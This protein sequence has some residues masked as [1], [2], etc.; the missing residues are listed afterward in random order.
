[1]PVRHRLFV[2]ITAWCLVALWPALLFGQFDLTPSAPL[3]PPVPF[4]NQQELSIKE[5]NALLERQIEEFRDTISEVHKRDPQKAARMVREFENAIKLIR[6]HTNPTGGGT[7]PIMGMLTPIATPRFGIASQEIQRLQD[8]GEVQFAHAF[9]DQLAKLKSASTSEDYQL[10]TRTQPEIHRVRL[11]SGT[12]MPV[13]YRTKA[14]RFNKSYAEVHVQRTGA[15]VILVLESRAPM[16]WNIKASPGVDVLAV[17]VE[18]LSSQ[19][20]IGLADP[21]LLDTASAAEQQL[22]DFRTLG[23]H[24]RGELLAGSTATTF[25]SAEQYQEPIILG[26]ASRQWLADFL[27]EQTE[28]LIRACRSQ[29][30]SREAKRFAELRYSAS[31]PIQVDANARQYC[32]AEFN[33]TGPI[34]D[35]L[36]PHPGRSLRQSLI[37][38][39]GKKAIHFGLSTSGALVTHDPADSSNVNNSSPVPLSGSIF[40]RNTRIRAFAYDSK[41]HRL[42]C[43]PTGNQGMLAALDIESGDWLAV[44]QYPHPLIG[45]AYA[46]ESDEIWAVATQYA[47]VSATTWNAATFLRMDGAGKVTSAKPISH[48]LLDVKSDGYAGT[49]VNRFLNQTLELVVVGEYA[50]LT[51]TRPVESG[52][53][54]EDENY[55]FVINAQTGELAYDGEL[56][57]NDGL[58]AP[59]PTE[60]NTAFSLLANSISMLSDSKDLLLTCDEPKK[61][62]AQARIDAIQSLLRGHEQPRQKSRVYLIGRYGSNQDV[63]LRVTDQS[64]AVSLILSSNHQVKWNIEVAAGVDLQRIIADGVANTNVK[65][66]GSEVPVEAHSGKDAFKLISD[67]RHLHLAKLSDYVVERTDLEPS[68]ILLLSTQQTSPATIGIGPANGAVRLKLAHHE[69]KSLVTELQQQQQASTYQSLKD[70]SFFA[71]HRGHLPGMRNEVA[72]PN[73]V[74]SVFWNE[75]T[76]RGPKIGQSTPA[77]RSTAFAAV[78]Q[79]S[80]QIFC[81]DLYRLYITDRE[82][83][84]VEN[85]NLRQLARTIGRVT[86]LHFDDLSNQLIIDTQ[87]GVWSF[88][89]VGKKPTLRQAKSRHRSIASTYSPSKRRWYAMEQERQQ[90]REVTRI[91]VYNEHYAFINDIELS[92]PLSRG[93]RSFSSSY[94][95]QLIVLDDFIAIIEQVQQSNTQRVNG[96]TISKRRFNGNITVVE[97]DSGQ[98]VYRGV[99]EPHIE[100]RELSENQLRSIWSNLKTANEK[101]SETLMWQMAA[102]GDSTLAFLSDQYS[103]LD[104]AIEIDLDSLVKKLDDNRFSIRE[105]AFR[106]LQKVGSK[107]EPHLRAIIA[108]HG[109]SPEVRERLESLIRQWNSGQPQDVE[110]LRQVRGVETIYRIGSEASK[111]FLEELGSENYEAYIRLQVERS[112]Q[113]TSVQSQGFHNPAMQLQNRLFVPRNA[114]PSR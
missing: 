83:G 52:N 22:L 26:P 102:G 33:L 87:T 68:A 35:T 64:G 109:A 85:I 38:P 3:P 69:L 75:F 70:K 16:L 88:D 99:L 73:R 105:S 104:P 76:L 86:G 21:L 62:D 55:H 14:N 27:D 95:P 59:I 36:V 106:R 47:P 93:S 60:R 39:D 40:G 112:R 89:P 19:T 24:S 32:R 11:T 49:Y 72:A 17:I 48:P 113:G 53:R 90:N 30:R 80:G 77:Y 34:A 81:A 44:G 107:L 114:A 63:N 9:R 43:A 103:K 82:T 46:A 12:T 58:D 6:M 28:S 91:R 8:L 7:Q 96:R 5:T 98:V 57:V 94:P 78:N 111:Q 29:R 18:S 67:N 108:Q 41:R 1:M 66:T 56:Q 100:Y 79:R 2:S 97:A 4:Q 51:G 13:R 65:V 61:R 101:D 20:V 25:Y 10:T 54:N 110:E 45:I 31:F 15:P 50:V 71:I 74:A 37:I 23:T 42:L 92:E 84:Q